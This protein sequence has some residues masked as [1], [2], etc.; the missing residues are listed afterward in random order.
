MA[1]YMGMTIEIGG[2]LP[3]QYI[4]KFLKAIEDEL[5]DILGPTTEEE[6]RKEAGKTITWHARTNYGMCE[7][8]KA[9]CRVHHLSYVHTCEANDECDGTYTYWEPEMDDEE[10]STATQD[11][12]MTVRVNHVRPLVMLLLEYAKKGDDALPLLISNDIEGLSEGVRHAIEK[13]LRKP[14]DFLPALE[15]EILKALPTGPVLKPF[16][17]QE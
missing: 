2:I 11:G 17:I 15:K 16:K 3:A 7:Q 8:L 5:T 10:G 12:D 6:L 4:H 9:L 1:E 13:G 14:K